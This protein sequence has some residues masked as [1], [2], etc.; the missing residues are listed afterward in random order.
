[1]RVRERLPIQCP[2][3]S[4]L[5][6]AVVARELIR[7]L[8][9]RS[10]KKV[11]LYLPGSGSFSL[12]HHSFEMSLKFVLLSVVLLASGAFADSEAAETRELAPAPA[13]APASECDM[14]KVSP[15]AQEAMMEMAGAGSDC[16]KLEKANKK[17][18]DGIKDGKCEEEFKDQPA[19][20]TL[21]DALDS[22]GCDTS[23]AKRTLA[24]ISLPFLGALAFFGQ[25]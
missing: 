10:G 12:A 1:V 13:P 9:N 8:S 24:T 14:G 16:D 5:A 19:M 22:A 7:S 20:K 18:Q 23:G 4:R 17:L 2:F 6:Q 25:H 3:L 11:S 15:V 21:K